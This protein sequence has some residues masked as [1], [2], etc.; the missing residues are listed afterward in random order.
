MKKDLV[1]Q[2]SFFSSRS[3]GAWLLFSVAI[4]LGL[5]ALGVFR[6]APAFAQDQNPGP[7]D[8]FQA[9]AGEHAAW[10]KDAP[11]ALAPGPVSPQ[12]VGEE[13]T[14]GGVTPM[15]TTASGLVII[16]TFD[17]SITGNPN[18]TAIEAMINQAVAI[19]QARFSDPI[20]V[21]IYFRYST[22]QPNGTPMGTSLARSNFV[23][24]MIP[25]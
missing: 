9:D 19:Y 18:A 10:R 11:S 4:L 2:S 7:S 22:T 15:T 6:T 16:P 20:T 24:Y 5:Y 25:W 14:P 17:S 21:R 8:V 12:S 3:L 13:I 23:T 1:S